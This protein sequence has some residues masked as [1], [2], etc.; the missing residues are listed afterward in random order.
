MDH[1][2]FIQTFLKSVKSFALNLPMLI[3]VILLSG[4]FEVFIT[5]QML[6]SLFT[7]QAFYDSLIGTVSGGVSV[8]QP[9]I[10]YLIAGELLDNGM[11]YYA[12]SAFVLS[13]VTLGVVQLPYE[14]SLFGG[15][16]TLTR[17]L[18]AFIFALLI[19]FATVLSLKLL[20]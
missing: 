17:N 9:F 5:P 16:F 18:L 13:W 4:L 3:A 1:P 10:S 6:S 12:V 20:S 7:G 2:T 19:S 14:Y 15:R 8:G 11:S